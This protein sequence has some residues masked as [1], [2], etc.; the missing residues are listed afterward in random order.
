MVCYIFASYFKYFYTINFIRLPK[1]RENNS[2]EI[3]M[4]TLILRKPQRKHLNQQKYRKR[5]LKQKKKK[6][7]WMI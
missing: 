7:I 4:M 5:K 3:L 6:R 1:V 2:G